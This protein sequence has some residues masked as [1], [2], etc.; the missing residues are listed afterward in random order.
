MTVTDWPS[1][2][3]RQIPPHT[4]EA[5]TAR[6]AADD[7]SLADVVRQAL[8]HHYNLDCDPA[9]FGYQPDN[10][11]GNDFLLV[12]VQPEVF[13]KMKRE[14]RG[15]Y[16]ATKTLVLQSLDDYLEATQ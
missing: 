8:C 15:R 11:T 12:R 4:R 5:M 2:L 16:G 3:L 7:I 1:Y 10:D 14:T 6:A 13:K 9:S